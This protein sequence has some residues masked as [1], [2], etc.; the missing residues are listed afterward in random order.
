MKKYKSALGFFLIGAYFLFA[1]LLYISAISCPPES[2]P[3]TADFFASFA[4]L[5]AGVL[6][7]NTFFD[8]TLHFPGWLIYSLSITVNAFYIYWIGYIIERKF[9][10]KG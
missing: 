5:P 2:R 4:I 8:S 6:F 1:T 9:K 7:A 3:C 10:K